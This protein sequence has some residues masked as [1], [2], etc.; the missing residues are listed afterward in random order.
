MLLMLS[1]VDLAMLIPLLDYMPGKY[2]VD[3]VWY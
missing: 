2:V 3:Y 1:V